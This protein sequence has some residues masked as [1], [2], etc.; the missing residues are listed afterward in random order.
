MSAGNVQAVA[1][2]LDV[3]PQEIYELAAEPGA[4]AELAVQVAEVER[5][6]AAL[7]G[8]GL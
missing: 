7:E 5:R 8:Q 6:V 3:D 4:V 2:A 1:R